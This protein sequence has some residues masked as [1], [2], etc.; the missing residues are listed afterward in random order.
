MY[1]KL[2]EDMSIKYEINLSD[3]Y[4]VSDK[5]SE[6]FHFHLDFSKLMRL[7]KDFKRNSSPG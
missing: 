7:I 5:D 6:N 3:H 4:K 1:S 2:L